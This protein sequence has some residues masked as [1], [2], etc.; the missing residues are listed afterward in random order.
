MLAAVVR[1]LTAVLGALIAA[2]MVPTLAA[3]SVTALVAVV[4]AA[5]PTDLVE[6]VSDVVDDAGV[7]TLLLVVLIVSIALLS[8]LV[9]RI[10][11]V[12][13]VLC[14]VRILRE[15]RHGGVG[16]TD[17]RSVVASTLQRDI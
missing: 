10:S 8:M 16:V 2:G 6:G 11:L 17:S 4:L 1:V 12:L 7:T 9:V 13:N 15:M 14:M 3:P 5:A